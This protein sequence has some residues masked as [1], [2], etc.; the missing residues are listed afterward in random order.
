M[1]YIILSRLLSDFKILMIM[2]TARPIGLSNPGSFSGEW[3]T[4]LSKNTLPPPKKN[5]M[6]MMKD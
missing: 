4:P 5:I 3:D 6:A 1:F 2:L